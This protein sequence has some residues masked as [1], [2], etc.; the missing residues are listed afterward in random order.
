MK[1]EDNL[2]NDY[3][4]YYQMVLENDPELMLYAVRLTENGNFIFSKSIVSL[5]HLR[6]MT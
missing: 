6:R 1:S 5:F 3:P 2:V 4:H